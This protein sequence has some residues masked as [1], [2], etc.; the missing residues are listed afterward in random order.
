LEKGVIV[1]FTMNKACAAGT[2]SFLEEQAEKLEIN[3]KKEFEQIAFSSD[4]PADLGDRCTVFME[5]AL[6]E[7]LQRGFPVPDL[8][9]GLAYSVA[10][11]YLNKVVENR[12][13]GNNIFFQGGTACNKSVV[14]AF[15]KILEKE[16]TVPPHNEVL[17][18]IGAAIVAMEATKGKSKF[19]G[20]AL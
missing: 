2:G 14:A 3:I 6:F 18:A 16:I 11:N 4:S 8:V 19:K 5:S 1:D 20:F 12:K 10:Y 17:G 9:G 15:E 7:H 13:I